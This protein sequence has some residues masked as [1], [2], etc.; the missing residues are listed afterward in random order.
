MGQ[1]AAKTEV[2]Q[3][4]GTPVITVLAL[5]AFHGGADAQ[6]AFATGDADDVT[7]ARDVAPIIQN[8][9]VVCH[10]P[11]GIGPMDFVTYEDVRRYSRRIREQ[12]ANRLM[13]PYYYD[14]D[15][16]IQG[17][18]GVAARLAPLRSGDQHG[19]GVGG[20]GRAAR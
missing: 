16:G 20:P 14:N 1:L 4:M 2:R 15:V 3:W 17:H 12:V 7:Y 10:R 5:L 8:S 13:P 9:C 19:R 18:P 11:G 6:A